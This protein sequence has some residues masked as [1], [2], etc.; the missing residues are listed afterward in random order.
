MRL[1]PG[2]NL[3][4]SFKCEIQTTILNDGNTDTSGCERTIVNASL[5]KWLKVTLLTKLATHRAT[6][7]IPGVLWVLFDG[8]LYD[9]E[10]R[11]SGIDCR[12]LPA[13][14]IAE[15]YLS[16]G[17]EAASFLMGSFSCC[18]LDEKIN[19]AYVITD[20]R[21]SRPLF[22]RNTND[23]FIA[24]PEI[25]QVIKS[26]G[27]SSPELDPAGICG[28][29]LS[30]QYHGANTLFNE[31]KRV[32]QG[33]VIEIN[34]NGVKEKRHWRVS[35]PEIKRLD[36]EEV[37]F[38]E[39][40]EL[41]T[42]A[43]SRVVSCVDKPILLLSGGLDSR[44][45]L[46]YLTRMLNQDVPLITYEYQRI[47]GE[48]A[49]VAVE[50]AEQIGLPI[51]NFSFDL[52]DFSDVAEQAVKLSDCSVEAI[53]APHV[54][55]MWQ[56]LGTNIQSVFKGDEC[57]GW[58][59]GVGTRQAALGRNFLFQLHSSMRLY[60]LLLRKGRG[61]IS[62]LVDSTLSN[63]LE[64]ITE[65]DLMDVKDK[66]Y[67]EQRIANYVNPFSTSILR[68]AEQARPLLDENVVDFVASLP[69]NYRADKSFIKRFMMSRH[70]HVMHVPLAKKHSLPMPSHYVD[71][72]KSDRV[73]REFFR[74]GVT[75]DL[76]DKLKDFV[77]VERIKK[78]LDA[79][80]E[81]NELPAPRLGWESRIPGIS[82][83]TG[84]KFENRVHPILILLRFLQV[85]LFL[86]SISQY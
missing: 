28:M 83:I 30:G 48:D 66:I 42:Q 12:K 26:F 74:E 53:E 22:S 24:A 38:D 6:Y 63:I 47:E 23:M 25:K 21:G 73:F 69:V 78:I 82:H 52:H 79:L 3:L 34:E 9:I 8:Y 84:V 27:R 55:T 76:N 33:T 7:R 31:V 67:Y 72:L 71:L 60:D 17:I 64:N 85:S 50:L 80:Q 62:S 57:F 20:R 49:K 40:D 56:D 45:L 65:V 43:I 37:L 86:N 14:A 19:C 77:D 70:P 44:I 15:S 11:E 35:F 1:V 13:R 41:Y 81:G 18:I 51:R 58:H 68:Q 36:E 29:V 59:A 54:V 16:Q 61:I 39:L 2:I 32:N 5:K 75:T 10:K 4:A 46:S